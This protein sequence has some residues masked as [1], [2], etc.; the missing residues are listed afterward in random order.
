MKK[1]DLAYVAGIFDGEGCICLRSSKRRSYTLDVS[2]VN[3]NEWLMQWLKFA[4]GGNCY[5]MQ[6]K[7]NEE[8]NWKPCWRWALAS[9]K[10][11]N[12]LEL[13][14]P[15]LRL[16]KP[17]ADIAIKFQR[18]RRGMGYPLT[19]QELAIEEA[20]RIVMTKLNRR[21]KKQAPT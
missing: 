13:I 12:F 1:V 14:H 11:M 21:G 10:A 15:Y 8:R 19:D 16:K 4:F 5:S 9:N 18:A 2:I 17:Q 6:Y 3:T 7:S 20:Q